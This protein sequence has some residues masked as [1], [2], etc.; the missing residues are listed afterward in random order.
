[1][2]LTKILKMLQA[3]KLE[4]SKQTEIKEIL[5]TLIESKAHEVSETRID[6]EVAKEKE[7]LTEALE[8]KFETY[9]DEITSKF[10]NFVDSVLEEEVKIPEKIV[11]FAK[12]GETYKDL[13]DQFKIRLAIDEG[14]LT[15][16]VK[17]LL[18]EAK[19]EI[20]SLKDQLNESTSKVLDLQKD[21]QEMAAH[22]YLRKKCDGLTES[23]KKHV[24][25]I[26][27]DEVIK[28]NIDKKFDIIVEATKKHKVEEE[29]D[30]K[31][32][33]SYACPA[34]GVNAEIKEGDSVDCPE[35]GEKMKLA[36]NDGKEGKKV[37]ESKGHSEVEGPIVEQVIEED[38]EA[39]PWTVM[40]NEWT[41]R[42]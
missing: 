3:D 24:I 19:E 38:V 31:E 37:E 39:T 13:I 11:E 15:D 36:E 26:L 25:A 10:S 28:E 22:I 29:D 40:L 33:K 30:N 1:M 42:L 21:A 6:E 8:T 12:Y 17:D 20:L 18:K 23:Q 5:E 27:G 34:C 32:T 35:C 41:K 14:V 4:E 9:K 2:D 16:E 7:K